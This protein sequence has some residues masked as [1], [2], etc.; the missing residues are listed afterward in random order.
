MAEV[1]KGCACRFC[2]HGSRA[3]VSGA[4]GYVCTNAGFSQRPECKATA[5]ATRFEHNR[6]EDGGQLVETHGVDKL[7]NLT[8]ANDHT[9]Y[10]VWRLKACSWIAAAFPGAMDILDELEQSNTEL[11]Q[12]RFETLRDNNTPWLPKLVNQIRAILVSVCSDEPLSI[13]GNTSQS[14]SRF[15]MPASTIRQI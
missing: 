13:V 5:R 15:R 10:V 3:R 4:A 8:V 9:S 14:A 6:G 1:E 11:R 2:Q 7:D 12:A